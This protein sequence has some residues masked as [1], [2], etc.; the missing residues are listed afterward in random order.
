[1][2]VEQINQEVEA[3]LSRLRELCSSVQIL[4]SVMNPDGTTS[5]CFKGTGDWYARKGLAQEFLDRDQARSFCDVK[6]TEF[7]DTAK[8]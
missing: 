1:M 2:T 4:A 5:G 6:Q 8:D 3:C 7:P